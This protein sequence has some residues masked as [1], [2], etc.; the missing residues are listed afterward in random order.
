MVCWKTSDL[1]RLGTSQLKEGCEVTM[2][3][4]I[5]ATH[6]VDA[7]DGKYEISDR[8]ISMDE[9]SSQFGQVRFSRRH[10]NE[11]RGDCRAHGPDF[12]SPLE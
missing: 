2:D 10:Q 9:I 8:T 11:Q 12:G 4:S 7:S 1:I 5:D 6:T 3:D